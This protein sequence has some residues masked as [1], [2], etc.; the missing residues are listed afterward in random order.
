[1]PQIVAGFIGGYVFSTRYKST[2]KWKSE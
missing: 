1:V 2:R